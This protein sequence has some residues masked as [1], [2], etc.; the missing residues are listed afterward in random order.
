[1][2]DIAACCCR[3]RHAPA[4]CNVALLTLDRQQQRISSQA[5]ILFELQHTVPSLSLS[6]PRSVSLPPTHAMAMMLRPMDP[7]AVTFHTQTH[8]HT[9]AHTLMRAHAHTVLHLWKQPSYS[10][11]CCSQHHSV[12]KAEIAHTITHLPTNLNPI[13]DSQH[14]HHSVAV[15]LLT[16]SKIIPLRPVAMQHNGMEA[17]QHHSSNT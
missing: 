10:T 17:P 4:S 12:S 8:T 16:Q 11:C 9:R 1:M 13:D 3:R 14:V 7:S 5:G 2:Y 15:A 6:L